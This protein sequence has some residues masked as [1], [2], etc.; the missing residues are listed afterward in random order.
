MAAISVVFPRIMQVKITKTVM[1][2]KPPQSCGG[3]TSG[4]QDTAGH[5]LGEVC[6]SWVC[7]QQKAEDFPPLILLI[8]MSLTL[9]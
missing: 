2:L 6:G 5:D 1:P 9:T 7:S 8:G 4:F 3:V